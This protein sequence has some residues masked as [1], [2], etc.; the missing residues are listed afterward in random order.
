LLEPERADIR[1]DIP[2]LVWRGQGEGP[3]PAI[4]SLHGG[5]GSKSD[6]D[7]IAVR[8]LVAHG[9]TLVTI[10]A[11][12]HGDRTP[13]GF[14]M[15]RARADLG[16]FLDIIERTARDLFAVIA[17]LRDDP[18]ID[19]DRIGVRG[20]SMG[21]YVVLMAVGLGL[22]AAAVLSICGG[23]DY[24]RI[25]ELRGAGRSHQGA[26]DVLKRAREVD[27]IYH[28]LAFPP[29]PVLMIHGEKDPIVPIA[30]QRSLY[31]ALAP[32]Y[33]ANPGDCLFLTHAGEHATPPEIERLGWEWLTRMLLG[34]H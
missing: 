10:D 11:Y 21:G 4:I 14:D 9:L 16:V 34:S 23:A 3:R 15:T 26:E 1:G 18:R 17:S 30:G 5:G 25:W 22:P 33:A 12:N 24:E 19:A 32:L 20:G 13:A 28:S 27:P 31:N 29:R 8:H 7:P 2:A 6:V